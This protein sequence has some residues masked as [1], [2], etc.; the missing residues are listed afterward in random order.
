FQGE[1][2][3]APNP[4]P[5]ALRGP[6]P[7]PDL[8]GELWYVEVGYV[9]DTQ[10]V[11]FNTDA[12]NP[13][14]SERS[15]GAAGADTDD[16]A[17]Y[18]ALNEDLRSWTA[19]HPAVQITLRQVGGG[20]Y[21]PKTHVSCHPISDHEVTLRCWAL[22]FY[23]AEISLTWQRDGEDQ[24]QD[25]ELVETTPVGDGTFQKWAALVV[26]PGE[27]Q[28]YMCHVQHEGLQEPLT[29][30][31]EPYPQP[32]VPIMGITVGLVLF[33]VTAAV[34]AGVVIWRKKCSGE[35]GGSYTQAASKQTVPR[36][37]M[38]LL[39]IP[40]ISAPTAPA[41]RQFEEEEE[42]P[43]V[44]LILAGMSRELLNTANMQIL[45]DHNS[46]HHS[47]SDH[48]E[49]QANNDAHDG[50]SGLRGG[51]AMRREGAL[52]SGLSPDL[53]EGFQKGF[54]LI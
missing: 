9:D 44:I 21:H 23:P 19:A 43:A 15:N 45:E 40:E 12:A 1:D 20:R 18:I 36:A 52:T 27:E 10:F 54:C 31:W 34:V 25:T 26:P 32:T 30:R 11:R 17:D 2:L 33:V 37:L 29:L 48:K 13:M 8:G 3:V 28:R 53:A 50:D 39:R 16:G 49:N 6:G 4:S 46:R 35:K 41:I 38:C 24:A 7:D 51:S 42:T 14:D 47:C 5:A 22:G